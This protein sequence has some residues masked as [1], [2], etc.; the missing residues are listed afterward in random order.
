MG[1]AAQRDG[2][3]WTITSHKI[4]GKVILFLVTVSQTAMT[5]HSPQISYV[6]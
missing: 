3:G 6:L 4:R 2:N 5:Q 1:K